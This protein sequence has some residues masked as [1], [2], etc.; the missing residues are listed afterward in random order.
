MLLFC[1]MLEMLKFNPCWDFGCLYIKMHVF[2][3]LRFNHLDE[4]FYNVPVSIS[5]CLNGQ[6][7]AYSIS[8]A[9]Y[10]N[11]Q[12]FYLQPLSFGYNIPGL[13]KWFSEPGNF[14]HCK[15]YIQRK[16]RLH[17]TPRLLGTYLLLLGCRLF[18]S[19]LTSQKYLVCSLYAF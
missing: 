4:N 5:K 2:D 11:L 10:L 15:V 1:V 16:S 7:L 12:I 13:Q 8:I 3:V 17:I 18:L 6:C 9:M 19:L 14:N